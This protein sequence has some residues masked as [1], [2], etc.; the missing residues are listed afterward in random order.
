[1]CGKHIL[2]S[3]VDAPYVSTRIHNKHF[4][5]ILHLRRREEIVQTSCSSC[6]QPWFSPRDPMLEETGLSMSA[7]DAIPKQYRVCAQNRN[8]F[9]YSLVAQNWR[10]SHW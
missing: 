10:S 9:L 6:V 1:M 3:S 5:V 4:I 7:S 8:L 2:S